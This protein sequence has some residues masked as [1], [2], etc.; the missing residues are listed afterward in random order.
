[1]VDLFVAGGETIATTLRW[2]VLLLAHH[3]EIQKKLQDEI[4]SVIGKGQP[5]IDDRKRYQ[6]RCYNCYVFY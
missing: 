5:T 1:M 4:D 2:G 3:N 6:T